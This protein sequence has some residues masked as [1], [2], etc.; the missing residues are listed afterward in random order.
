[1]QRVL[2]PVATAARTR[3]VVG[4]MLGAQRWRAISAF[5]V[6][7][8]STVVYLATAPLL[9]RIID[10]VTAGRPASAIS[11]PVAL[12]AVCAAGQ[13][14][15]LAFGLAAVAEV[16]ERTLADLRERF[17]DRA[18]RLPLEQ[19]EE[20]GSGDLTSRVGNDVTVV[21]EAVREALPAMARSV[22][23]ILLTLVGL[24]VLDWR[25]LIAALLAVPVQLHTVRWYTRRAGHVYGSHRVAVG[26]QQQ[27]LL[28]TVGGASTV[29][30]FRL[31]EDHLGRVE[32]ASHGAID[33]AM[34]GIRL[35]TRFYARL[36]LAELIGLTAVLAFGFVLVRDDAVS[37]GTATAAALYFHGLFNPINVA[38]ALIDD[39]QAA[40]ASLARLVGVADQTP[41]EE[42]DRSTPA[43]VGVSATG[44]HHTYNGRT[45]VLHGV[46]LTVRPGGRV[47]LVGASGAGK[48]TLAKLIAGI[49]RPTGGV[50]RVGGPIVLVTQEVHV[51]AGPL[52]DDLR[53]AAPDATDDQV[54]EALDAVGATGWVAALPDG[55]STVVGEGG[56][57]LTAAQAQHL[58]LARLVLADP[59]VVILDEAT[60]E[61][62]SAGARILEA[63]SAKALAGRSALVVAHRLT[64]AAAADHVV[65]MEA[66]RIVEEGT[67]D[68]LVAAGGTYATLWSAWSEA[69]PAPV[70]RQINIML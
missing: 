28:D 3:A 52:A 5:G 51:F 48:T 2:L 59:P 19:V 41:P 31:G 65:V 27:R 42:P 57:R 4:G 6:L 35:V 36:N 1:M 54:R 33:L 25:F 8:L 64:Q 34:Q 69:R 66:G 60:A 68:E 10:L 53:L 24:A 18:L 15:L 16:G 49:H 67:H 13:G 58:A 7:V 30:A 44:V 56:H 9:G 20:A 61:A 45:M 55:L 70:H 21:A 29:R 62:G 12:L 14:A 26:E 39:A 32:R 23:T 40:L 63:A 50:I 43:G 38:L 11:V 47:A 37:V 46:D 17:V 22:L